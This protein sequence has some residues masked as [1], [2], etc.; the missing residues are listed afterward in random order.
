MYVDRFLTKTDSVASK[1]EQNHFPQFMIISEK[2]YVFATQIEGA[3]YKSERRNAV[4][5]FVA[6]NF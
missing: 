4:V 3:R 6:F 2:H 5:S 1:L